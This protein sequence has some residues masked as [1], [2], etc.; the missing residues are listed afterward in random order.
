MRVL[1]ALGDEEVAHGYVTR[2]INRRL[3]RVKRGAVAAE[4]PP[5]GFVE[6]CAGEGVGDGV[7]CEGVVGGDEVYDLRVPGGCFG[8]GGKGDDGGLRDEG[9]RGEGGGDDMRYCVQE[10]GADVEDL[11]C[12]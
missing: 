12:G 11:V 3:G 7:V 4:G 2:I 8:D 9:A 10:G 5:E 6:G 1:V